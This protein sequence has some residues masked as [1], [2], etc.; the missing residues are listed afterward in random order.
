MISD[1]QLR[2]A[3]RKV[4]E[5]MLAS[6]PEPEECEATFSPEFE[7]K[8]EKLLRRVEHPIRKR[9]MKAVACLLLV[10]LVGGGSVLTFS[11]EARATFVGWVR[12]VYEM[13][14]SY[15][16]TGEDKLAPQDIIYCPTWLP[17]GYEIVSE[18][19][20]EFPIYI[21]YENALG[22][23][24]TFSC[25]TNVESMEIQ[26]D[27][28]QIEVQS[29][30]V[31]DIMASLYVEQDKDDANILIWPDDEKG[32]IFSITAALDSE[33]LIKIAESVQPKEK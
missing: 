16:Y 20:T 32:V 17:S 4:E 3:A 21:F 1:E 19:D 26:I 23:L 33:D 7:R 8:M 5:S 13:Y 22:D 11:V 25:F 18:N 2:E 6:L 28:D 9:I 30:L 29:V 10:F 14:F 12:E 15:H 24:I 27:R 31:G